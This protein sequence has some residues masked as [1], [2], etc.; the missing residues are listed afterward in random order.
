MAEIYNRLEAG[1]RLRSKR[2]NIGWS[3]ERAAEMMN[4]SA[5]YYAD[6]ERGT[7]GMSI[8]TLITLCNVY[9]MSADMILFGEESSKRFIDDKVENARKKVGG[10]CPGNCSYMVAKACGDLA[11]GG[12]GAGG[13]S[14]VGGGA[15]SKGGA[16]CMGN[17]AS[18]KTMALTGG[19]SAGGSSAD[20]SGSCASQCP[21][22]C[23]LGE[24]YETC[25]KIFLARSHADM[26]VFFNND[27]TGAVLEVLDNSKD[28]V[29][30]HLMSLLKNELEFSE[31]LSPTVVANRN[32]RKASDKREG[33]AEG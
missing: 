25:N 18:A 29:R 3:Q 6:I 27:E 14:S 9:Q 12:A 5:K 16:G 30:D 8:E 19:C 26:K 28:V 11:G 20:D 33:D 24:D 31:K 10:C 13:S 7:C 1:E 32:R 21:E 22:V 4:L 15:G 2:K 17:I 23:P